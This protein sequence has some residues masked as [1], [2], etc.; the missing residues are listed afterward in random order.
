[1]KRKLIGLLCAC[2]LL[3]ACG[4]SSSSSLETLATLPPETQAAAIPLLDQGVALEESSN[5]L[6]IPN[7]AMEDMVVPEMRL[8]GNGLLF[9]QWRENAMVLRHISLEDGSMLASASLAAGDGTRLSI[10]SGEIGL[11]DREMGRVSILDEKF[12]LLRS[13]DVPR[14]GDDWYLNSELDTLYI[15]Y[16]NWGLK[17]HDLETGKEFWLVE[18]GFQVESIGN[19]AGY[20][21]FTYTDR[22]D[23][24]TDTRCLNLSTATLETL[25]VEGSASEMVRQ[26]DTWLLS[27]GGNHTLVQ[28]E[29][30]RSFLWEDSPVQLL[31]LRRH[32]L[33]SDPSGRTLTLYENDGTF[34]SR[35]TLPMSSSA[36]VGPDFVW[37]GYWDGYFFVDYL[38]GVSR[39][40]FWDVNS[41][42]KDEDLP[43]S[44]PEEPQQVQSVLEAQLY[45]RAAELSQRFGVEIRIGEQCSLDYS[46]YDT[47]AVNDPIYIRAALD[48]L[49]TGMSQYPE[50]FFR[51]LTYGSIESIRIDLVG[52]IWKKADVESHPNSVKAFVTDRGSH[53]IIVM[54]SFMA[55]E[56]TLFHEFSHIID[57]RLAWDSLIREGAK[58]SEEAWLALQPEGFHYA[59]SYIQTPEELNAFLE[60]GFFISE[61]AMTNSTEDRA[62]LI[63]TAMV[64][65]AEYFEENTCNRAKMQ[66]YADCIRE[67]FDTEGWPEVTLWEQVLQ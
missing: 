2:L 16:Y 67:C 41:G 52:S 25:P 34:L 33:L 66:F 30:L 6:Y 1:M 8:L 38:D 62:V 61:Y 20:I 23:Q 49:E 65:K 59:E 19:S 26:G 5:L 7:P 56:K 51:Q 10:G 58:Y 47:F 37:S 27:N 53:Y 57:D 21:L 48:V 60:A 63:A 46:H 31:P 18:N 22:E 11:C 14:E 15:F 55:N 64:Q 3:S 42:S 28:G 4:N 45:E 44:T 32:L 35:C 29:N 13:Y 40:M 17:V 12:Q 36:M 39:L 54:D 24:K 43:L 9:S 50:G